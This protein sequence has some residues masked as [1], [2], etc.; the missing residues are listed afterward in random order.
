MSFILSWVIV[1][2][3]VML[4]YILFFVD[5]DHRWADGFI[6]YPLVYLL[7]IFLWPIT[8]L[9]LL[10]SRLATTRHAWRR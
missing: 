7:T 3:V 6:G 9:C 5:I 1:G 8:V 2:T 4:A 10:G